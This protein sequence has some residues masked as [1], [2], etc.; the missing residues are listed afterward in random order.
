MHTF[1]APR[2][3]DGRTCLVYT[4]PLAGP[5]ITSRVKT[6]RGPAASA[7]TASAAFLFLAGGIF[8]VVFC[9]PSFPLFP[10][11]ENA[12]EP[13]VLQGNETGRRGW[14]AVV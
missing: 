4:E 11:T 9:P 10:L 7:S 14:T 1:G 2:W 6:S 3:R 12:T 13:R 8:V 5:S